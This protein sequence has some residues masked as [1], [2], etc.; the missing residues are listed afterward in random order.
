MVKRKSG[1][2]KVKQAKKAVA[3]KEPELNLD[4]INQCPECGGNNIY[5]SKVRSEII[6][7]DCGAIFSRLTPGREKR[8][9]R[10]SD[11]V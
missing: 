5:L 4:K 10:A 6:C 8:F 9:R 3:S 11:I 7:K 1:K 2:K